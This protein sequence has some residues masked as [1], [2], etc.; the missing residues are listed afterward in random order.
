MNSERIEN[1]WM[2]LKR[3]SKREYAGVSDA[4]MNYLEMEFERLAGLLQNRH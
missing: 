2:K 3:G 1:F 4:E